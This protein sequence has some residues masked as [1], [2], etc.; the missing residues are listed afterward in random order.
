MIITPYNLPPE[1]CT[2]KPFMVL[3]CLIPGPSN[4]MASINV[5]LEPLIDDLKKL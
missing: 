3:M 1:M 4:L 2:T 5:Y